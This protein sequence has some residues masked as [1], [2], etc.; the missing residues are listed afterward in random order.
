MDVDDRSTMSV[1]RYPTSVPAR[2]AESVPTAT[3]VPARFPVSAFTVI[4]GDGA[5]LATITRRTE[6]LADG[7]ALVVVAVAED[8]DQ[9]SAP[10]LRSV[11]LEALAPDHSVCCDVSGVAFFGAA[12]AATVLDAHRFAQARGAEFTVRGARGLARE[13]LE[14]VGL[15]TVLRPGE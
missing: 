10:A 7:G 6:R 11:L 13:V 15:R 1:P 2:A 12:A 14:F 3:A 4:A 5:A 9:D 8:I